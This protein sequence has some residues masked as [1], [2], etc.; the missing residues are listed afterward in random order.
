MSQFP[1][2]AGPD[3][4]PRCSV[5]RGLR[6]GAIVARVALRP[7]RVHPARQLP[8]AAGAEHASDEIDFGES[9]DGFPNK[10]GVACRR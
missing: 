9:T 10:N 4:R 3:R 7:R 1:R 2:H 8:T 6:D 5:L